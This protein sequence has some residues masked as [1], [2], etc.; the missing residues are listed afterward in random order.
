M[1]RLPFLV[2]PYSQYQRLRESAEVARQKILEMGT[3]LETQRGL[4]GAVLKS[5]AE[6][7][8]AVDP[9]GK[10]ILANRAV[11]Q[12]FGVIEPEILG[13]TVRLGIRNNE[14][15]DL[16]EEAIRSKRAVEKEI[17][18]MVPVEGTFV[19]IASPILGEG[20]KFQ[21]VVCVLHN[22]TE[23]RRLE[24][25][26]SEFAANVSHE[27]KTPLTAILSY[28][29]TLLGGALEDKEHRRDFINKINKHALALS[30]LIDDLL[31]ISRLESKK[32]LG[33]FTEVDLG[34]VLNHAFEAISD[35]AKR[36]KVVLENKMKD[37]EYVVLGIE[38]HIYRAI[39]NL[40]DNAVN[41]TNPGGRVEITCFKED[42]Q[43]KVV[44][45]DTG[46]GISQEHL[47]RIFERFYRVDK[48]RSR[49]L[50]GTGLGLSIV[51]H[52][53]EIHQ[54]KVLVE[55]EVGKGSKFTLVFNS[56]V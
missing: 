32:E 15:A 20:E 30:T 56:L 34:T 12:M 38:D 22:I 19:A 53:M 4:G 11:E 24:K 33:P 23:L 2:L 16:T 13:R 6:G 9:E 1:F 14:I 39:F 52:V 8:L 10:I 43:I 21:G 5:M 7:V 45:S 55:S 27:L 31:E 49:D 36:K 26:R 37:E 54:G 50:G 28:V 47:P 51:K 3:L 29:E 18:I 46:I 44:V 42:S 40:L 48:A 17:N 35:K 41:Y 25:Y